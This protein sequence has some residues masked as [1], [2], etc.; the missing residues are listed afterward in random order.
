MI[1]P[2]TIINVSAVEESTARALD[3][4]SEQQDTI[5]AIDRIVSSMEDAWDSEAQRAYAQSFRNSRERIERFSLSVTQ[6][7]NNMRSFVNDCV[8]ADELT[9]MEIRAVAW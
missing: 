5:S 8:S 6:S 9:A 7:V 2:A 3:F 4:V 1:L